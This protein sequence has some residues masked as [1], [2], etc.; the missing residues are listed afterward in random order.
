MAYYTDPPLTT[1]HLPA[2]E[3]AQ[4]ASELLL[5]LL[6]GRQVTKRKIILDT[7]L[8]VRNSCGAYLAKQ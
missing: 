7:H 2:V 8:V 5:Q 1:V 6:K 3:L 4:Q